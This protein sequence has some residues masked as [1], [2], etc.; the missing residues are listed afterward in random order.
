MTLSPQPLPNRSR[1]ARPRNRIKNRVLGLRKLLEENL[2]REL[3]RLGIERAARQ[4]NQ[5]LLPFR[6]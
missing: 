1:T 2:G 3:K 6:E 5:G 4:G